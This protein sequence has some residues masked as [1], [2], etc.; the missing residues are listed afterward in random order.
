MSAYDVLR[1][2]L[3][4]RPIAFHP[5]LARA[6]G[7]INEALFFQQIAYWSDKGDDPE[8]IYKRRVELEHERGKPA[9]A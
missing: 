3:S 9:R 7:G 8:W 2:I 5:E 4:D 1:R 6:F